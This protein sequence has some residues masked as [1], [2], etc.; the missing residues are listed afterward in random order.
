MTT[1]LKKEFEDNGFKTNEII[2]HVLLIEDFLTKEELD[3][4]WSIIDSTPEE[5]WKIE[6]LSNLENFCMTKFG[7][8][9]VEN[10]IA[11]GK[12]EVTQNWEDKNLNIGKYEW[13]RDF[14][15][16]LNNLVIKANPAI[17]VSGLQTFQRMQEGVELKS[18]TDQNTDPSIKYAAIV[19]IN[20]DYIEGEFFLKNKDLEI[21]PR[22]G[23]ILIFPG[24]EEFEHGVKHVGKGPIRY[25]I[26]GFIKEK[27]HYEKNR[28]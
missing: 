22:P 14:Y 2:E 16:R 3:K 25:V 12:Y 10:L 23:S 1:F 28:Y 13:T 21:R 15:N 19:Y 18:H 4:L 24:N 17:E 27:D 11:E 26:V 7:R 5:D 8:S 9:D 6:Y 20:D